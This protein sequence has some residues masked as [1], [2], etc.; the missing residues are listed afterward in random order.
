MGEETDIRGPK[1]AVEIPVEVSYWPWVLA[2]AGVLL[3]LVALW[4][5]LRGR[6]GRRDAVRAVTA[7]E[8]A[9]AA[10]DAAREFKEA[11]SSREFA[12]AVSDAVRGFLEQ[13]FGLPT[14]RQTTEEF[15]RTVAGGGAGLGPYRGKLAD[16]LGHCDRVK[17]GKWEMSV[18]EMDVLEQSA[19]AVINAEFADEKPTGEGGHA[20][21][22]S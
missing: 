9:V 1:G 11:A 21:L 14:T 16:F 20:V 5:F 7:R 13:R 4:Y 6:R 17:F 8:R 10:V 3:L 15:L 18:G 19:M 22:A 12:F 2:G